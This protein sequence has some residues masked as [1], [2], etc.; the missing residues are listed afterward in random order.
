MTDECLPNISYNIAD[1]III[2]TYLPVLT[3]KTLAFIYFL[4]EA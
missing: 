1:T 2:N 3:T 4:Q